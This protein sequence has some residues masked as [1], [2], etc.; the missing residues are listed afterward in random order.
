MGSNP[1]KWRPATKLVRGGLQRSAFKETSEALYLTSGFVYDSPEEGD[2][3]FAGLSPGYQYTRLANPTI[4]AFEERLAL[5]EG[6]QACRATA[7]GM[8]A[9][10]AVLLGFLKAGD[11]IVAGRALFGSCRWV[12][13]TLLPRFGVT[14][15]LVDAGDLD[16]WRAH[17]PGAA[18]LFLETPTNPM[19]DVA[20]IAAIAA[21]GRAAGALTVV[22]NVFATPVLQKPLALGADLVVYST[23]KHIDGHGRTLGGAIL[24][25]SAL[26][27]GTFD[28]FLRNTGPT[29]SP[30]NA[31]VQLKSLETIELRVRRQSESA[32]R[33]ADVL[34]ASPKV[35]R[36][37]YPFRSDHPGVAIARRQMAAGGPL[38]AF[39]VNGGREAAFRVLNDLGL[40]DISNNLGDAKSLAVHPATTTHRRLDPLERERL[41]VEEGAIRLSVG[42]EDP[43]DLIEDLVTA[44]ESL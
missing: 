12:I 13:E 25:E 28:E 17:A 10:T 5:L 14:S 43:D 27:E 33:I 16:Q 36:V 35:A 4:R 31:W 26:L 15:V 40:I 37:S 42:L 21:I 38:V 9:V 41:G 39:V 44:L 29:L 6:A 23:T 32:A 3:R 22:D 1:K 8:A 18:M 30:F 34:A 24:G 11:K 20:D 7:T 19:L 2:A